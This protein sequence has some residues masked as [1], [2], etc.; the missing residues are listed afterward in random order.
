MRGACSHHAS[1][2][3]LS[4][5]VIGAF[6]RGRANINELLKLKTARI[7]AVC[8]VNEN[9]LA[10]VD[11]VCPEARQYTDFRKMLEAEKGLDAV[12][13]A[14]ADHTHAP[15]TLMAIAAGCHVYTEKPLAHSVFEAQ[16]DDR[17]GGESRS[18]SRRLGTKIHAGESDRRVVETVRSGAIGPVHKAAC[19]RKQRL[20]R[21]R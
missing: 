11:E 1:E 18:A 7:V 10:D 6:N 19:F 8:D 16:T 17:G 12:L 20:G 15:A 21:R 2:R 13:T 5:A 3:A 4:I 9:Y 14:T